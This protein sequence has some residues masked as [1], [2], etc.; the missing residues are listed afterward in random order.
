MP[1][2]MEERP[3]GFLLD[4]TGHQNECWSV[5]V[6]KLRMR[7]NEVVDDRRAKFH[8]KGGYVSRLQ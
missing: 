3:S 2:G 6:K 1:E 4:Q 7:I 5:R 8:E